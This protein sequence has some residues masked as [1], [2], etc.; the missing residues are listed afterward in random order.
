MSKNTEFP[1]VVADVRDKFNVVINMGRKDGIKEGQKFLIYGESDEEIID[2]VSKKS[3]GILEI[4]KGT[5]KVT[6]V[7]ELMSTVTSDEKKPPK[8]EIIKPK[9]NIIGYPNLLAG[10]EIIIPGEIKPFKNPRVGDKAK[11]I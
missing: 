7:Q 11:P 8:R 3:L 10:K 9:P 2:P 6:I 1:A 5:G 4:V